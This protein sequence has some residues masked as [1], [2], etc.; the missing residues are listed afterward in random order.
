MIKIQILAVGNKIEDSFSKKDTTL[1][2][3]SF[4][5]RRLEE[6]KQKLLNIDYKSELEISEDD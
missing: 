2:E 3:N 6:I 1:I 5:I 4:V